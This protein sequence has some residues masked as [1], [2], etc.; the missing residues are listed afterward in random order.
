M[1]DFRRLT[2]T[3]P[4]V[5]GSRSNRCCGGPVPPG[6]RVGEARCASPDPE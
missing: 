4:V 3:C 1:S 5:L 6:G 2:E